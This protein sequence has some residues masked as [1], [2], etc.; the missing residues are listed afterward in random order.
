MLPEKAIKE[1][2]E[3]MRGIPDKSILPGAENNRKWASSALI[4]FNKYGFPM[5]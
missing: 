3:L 2:F 1:L 5:P 4:M